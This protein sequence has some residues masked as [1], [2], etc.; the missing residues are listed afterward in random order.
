MKKVAIFAALCLSVSTFAKEVPGGPIWYTISE[1]I[2][3]GSQRLIG[4]D[5]ETVV[6]THAC[7][8]TEKAT[9]VLKVSTKYQQKKELVLPDYFAPP[10]AKNVWF[11]P[12]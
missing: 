5:K 7:P 11:L 2:L 1:K 6:K 10:V 8:K 3:A 4:M 12:E 9:K